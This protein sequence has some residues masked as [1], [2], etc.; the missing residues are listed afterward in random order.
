M[1]RVVDL[2]FSVSYLAR[3]QSKPTGAAEAWERE[4]LAFRRRNDTASQL[5]MLRHVVVGGGSDLRV[6][7]NQK[8]QQLMS[9]LNSLE[10]VDGSHR[11]F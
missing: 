9:V 7:S 11:L 8:M 1:G 4:M 2:C 6:L 3:F 5:N 10:I